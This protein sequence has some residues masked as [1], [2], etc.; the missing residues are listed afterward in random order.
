VVAVPT[1]LFVVAVRACRG[2]GGIVMEVVVACL[3]Q[4]RW[5]DREQ[6]ESHVGCDVDNNHKNNAFQQN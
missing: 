1:V 4:L 3:G 5:D 2:C 6:A